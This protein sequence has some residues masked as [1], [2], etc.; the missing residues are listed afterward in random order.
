MKRN[1]RSG[2]DLA[3]QLTNRLKWGFFKYINWHKKFPKARA[4]LVIIKRELTQIIFVLENA[5]VFLSEISSLPSSIRKLSIICRFSVSSE[6]SALIAFSSAL[7]RIEVRSTSETGSCSETEIEYLK[8]IRFVCLCM[9]CALNSITSLWCW[10]KGIH[11]GLVFANILMSVN[12]GLQLCIL[13]YKYQ[14]G[15]WWF[16]SAWY[17]KLKYGGTILIK[18]DVINDGKLVIYNGTVSDSIRHET[19]KFNFPSGWDGY[20][21]Q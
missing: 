6:S 15:F 8:S 2:T 5:E 3:E 10:I 11:K 12:V 1:N 18:V 4:A 17:F 20:T 19:I 21:K 16:C 7:D 14:N 13:V 9:V